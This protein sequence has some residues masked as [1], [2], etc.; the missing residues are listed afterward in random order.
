VRLHCPA[1]D[2]R[3]VQIAP[4]SA[5]YQRPQNLDRLQPHPGVHPFQSSTQAKQTPAVRLLCL[6]AF[7]HL[8]RGQIKKVSKTRR[9]WSFAV[10]FLT[11]SDF[12]VRFGPLFTP[13][14]DTPARL[15]DEFANNLTN[16]VSIFALPDSQRRPHS[17]ASR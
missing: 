5:Q 1:G 8:R 16:Q 17:A 15:I 2:R 7:N 11:F 10:L 12:F 4:P 3:V 14:F 13:F 9:F 6:R